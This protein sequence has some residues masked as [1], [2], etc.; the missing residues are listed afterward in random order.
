MVSK[1]AYTMLLLLVSFQA[2]YVD[3]PTVDLLTNN[4]VPKNIG[5]YVDGAGMCV[6]SSI[7]GLLN[8]QEIYGYEEFREWAAKRPE[9]GGA[10]PSKVDMYF[11]EYPKAKNTKPVQ[12]VSVEGEGTLELIKTALKSGRGVAATDGGD[13]SYYKRYV[14]HMTNIVKFDETNNTVWIVDNNRLI[15]E[16][17]PYQEW[18]NR[19]SFGGRWAIVLLEKPTL[20]V[21]HLPTP[22]RANTEMD[23]NGLLAS[24]LLLMSPLVSYGQWGG[25]YCPP[26]Y[27]SG[28]SPVM[29][30]GGYLPQNDT[31]C[32]NG[33]CYTGRLE[34][35]YDVPNCTAE[36]RAN[37]L[38]VVGKY[39]FRKK[40]FADARGMVATCP[41]K[42]PVAVEG[43]Q[44]DKIGSSGQFITGYD[45]SELKR[46]GNRTVAKKNGREVS[47]N[48]VI[49][50]IQDSRIND[51]TKPCV[52]IK[53]TKFVELWERLCVSN[54][55]VKNVDSH[56][57]VY[58]Y[59]DSSNGLSDKLG[60][61][62]GVTIL[63]P[64][65][66]GHSTHVELFTDENK[67]SNRNLIKAVQKADPNYKPVTNEPEPVLPS[68][69]DNPTGLLLAGAIVVCALLFIPVK[70]K[71]VSED[72]V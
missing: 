28:F 69:G 1:F 41:V 36:L 35:F 32:V 55:E 4:S 67:M 33:V 43:M 30:Q 2:P 22:K 59:K 42:E 50:S 48:D 18:V 31:V 45:P 23:R 11:S 60:Y 58:K 12:Y 34:W 5:S 65:V 16:K 20:P 25:G 64:C 29:F 46:Q 52:V 63:T 37:G 6:A 53:G 7:Q 51:T 13:K 26:N 19:H 3:E 54:P 57:K 49:S 56:C 21:P 70:R 9:G 24:S 47:Y 68:V 44:L 40:T 39:D 15:V 66:E 62:N 8:N 14:Y 17:V 27:V 38:Q 10:G 71:P 72:M 61:A